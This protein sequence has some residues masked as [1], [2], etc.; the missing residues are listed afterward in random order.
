MKLFRFK[1]SR[2]SFKINKIILVILF[3]LCLIVF[4]FAQNKKTYINKNTKPTVKSKVVPA[5][6]T[7]IKP[8]KKNILQIKPATANKQKKVVPIQKVNTKIPK[9]TNTQNKNTKV[10]PTKTTNTKPL[11][12]I[13]NKTSN[14]NNPE[15][16]NDKNKSKNKD[17][18]KDKSKK[19]NDKQKYKIVKIK[20]QGF[21]YNNKTKDL[22]AYGEVIITGEDFKITTPE[23]IYNTENETAKIGK[24]F[25]F[26]QK[27][28]VL[29]ATKLDGFFK[30][31][32]VFVEGN[33]KLIQDKKDIKKKSSWKEKM[34]GKVTVTCDKMTFLY[35]IKQGSAE[36]NIKLVQED[37]TA[38][39]DRADYDGNQDLVVVKG[40]VKVEQ[41]NG[42]N[43]QCEEI[44]ISLK[45]DWM[46]AK[47]GITGDMKIEE[48]KVPE[49]K[50]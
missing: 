43:F 46:E 19:E 25:I 41:Q 38:Y 36:G 49:T 1:I 13:N 44:V 26:T 14:N 20:A 39:G 23:A 24:G 30:E 11:Q 31:K 42:D 40:N 48:E 10:I 29:T 27:G 5:S 3:N 28:T 50:F 22:F 37:T 15:N 21:R 7:Q 34:K 45:D 35:G 2:Q 18:N 47:G 32:K 17:K 6:K 12:N 16:K 9:N 8:L 4:I 33:V